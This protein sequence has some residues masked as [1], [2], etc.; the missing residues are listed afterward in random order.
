M[1]GKM[2]KLRIIIIIIIA[3]RVLVD[4]HLEPLTVCP[5]YRG[6]SASQH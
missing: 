1:P 4:M 3:N 5:N 6:L 2:G